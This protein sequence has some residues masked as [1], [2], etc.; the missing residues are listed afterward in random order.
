MNIELTCWGNVVRSIKSSDKWIKD[1]LYLFSK[2]WEF[3]ENCTE[4]PY[5]CLE[6]SVQFLNR[7]TKAF[8]S[9]KDFNLHRINMC[10]YGKRITT[11]IQMTKTHGNN[12]QN[13]FKICK[14]LDTEEIFGQ[15]ILYKY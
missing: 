15:I 9:Y 5:I 10:S 2:Y 6:S 3:N 12:I 13:L 4:C 7:F 14:S 11:S 8:T 1:V